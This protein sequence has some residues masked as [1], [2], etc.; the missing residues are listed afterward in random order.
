MIKRLLFQKICFYVLSVCAAVLFL[1]SN[2]ALAVESVSPDPSGAGTT[3]VTADTPQTGQPPP[4]LEGVVCQPA[5]DSV[6]GDFKSASLSL[7][8]SG[9]ALTDILAVGRSFTI[10]CWNKADTSPDHKDTKV[11]DTVN[12][13]VVV[14]PPA[15]LN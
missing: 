14:P 5:A 11:T 3:R 12:A 4:N 6:S 13:T 1:L 7:P 2:A 15:I 9:D 8:L 10:E